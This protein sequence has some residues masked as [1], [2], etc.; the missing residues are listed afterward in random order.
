VLPSGCMVQQIIAH[1]YGG[2][3]ITSERTNWRREEG[4][5]VSALLAAE[6]G[7]WMG[8]RKVGYGSTHGDGWGKGKGGIDSWRRRPRERNIWIAGEMGEGKMSSCVAAQQFEKVDRTFHKKIPQIYLRN[9]S[10][11]Y[12][13]ENYFLHLSFSCI[14]RTYEL[15]KFKKI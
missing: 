14:Y 5:W 13:H 1:M 6:G 9:I 11:A 12:A 4:C 7:I 3:R 8:E 15:I 2:I 10:Y